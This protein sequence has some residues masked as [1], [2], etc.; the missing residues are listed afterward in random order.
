MNSWSDFPLN[1]AEAT[2]TF[3]HIWGTAISL[4]CEVFWHTGKRNLGLR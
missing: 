2:D 3:E 1:L 4:L